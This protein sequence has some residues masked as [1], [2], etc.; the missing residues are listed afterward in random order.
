[1]RQRSHR[2][3]QITRRL[4]QHHFAAQLAAIL[5]EVGFTGHHCEH[6]FALKLALGP[7]S[8]RQRESDQRRILRL[9]HVAFVMFQVPTLSEHAPLLL[10]HV[11]EAVLLQ[12]FHHP[13]S[14]GLE[15]FR[16]GHAR[17]V[18]I[19][20]VEQRVHDLRILERFGFDA[21]D[22][23]EVG[24]VLRGLI[25]GESERRQREHKQGSG[26]AHIHMSILQFNFACESQF[27]KRTT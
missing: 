11:A 17:S 2:H 9:Q 16:V 5:L 21:V 26:K 20:K 1:M 23:G 15:A 14:G 3:G 12:P 18:R 19:A 10:L 7:F 13:G 6:G 4:R 22:N 24:L 25:R 27:P 8:P